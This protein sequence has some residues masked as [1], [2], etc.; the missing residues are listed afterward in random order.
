M[1]ELKS[2]TFS[3]AFNGMSPRQEINVQEPFQNPAAYFFQPR[4]Q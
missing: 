2:Q 1:I 4:H 3:E